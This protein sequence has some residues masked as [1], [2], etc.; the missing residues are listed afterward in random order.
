MMDINQNPEDIV[1]KLSPTERIYVVKCIFLLKK[2]IENKNYSLSLKSSPATP[3]LS[4]G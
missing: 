1:A 4:F 2:K 3:I